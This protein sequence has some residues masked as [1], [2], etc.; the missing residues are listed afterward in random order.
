MT[1][2][3]NSLNPPE[4]HLMENSRDSTKRSKRPCKNK[5]NILMYLKKQNESRQKLLQNLSSLSSRNDC[6]SDDEIDLLTRQAS[7]VLKKLPSYLQIKAMHELFETLTKYK[8]LAV[9][10]HCRIMYSPTPSS[11]TSKPRPGSAESTYHITNPTAA[12][13]NYN[14]STTGESPSSASHNSIYSP[15][16]AASTSP[17]GPAEF[18]EYAVAIATSF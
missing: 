1:D 8:T 17:E 14:S 7:S 16:N 5:D 18:N 3:E 11:S 12:T 6:D 15:I 13:A 9:Q 2:P 4:I 10:S